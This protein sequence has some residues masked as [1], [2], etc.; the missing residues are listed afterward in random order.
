MPSVLVAIPDLL[1]A[2]KVSATARELGQSYER[3]SRKAALVDE[4]ARTGARRG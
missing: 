1:F 2:S 3:A 4:V